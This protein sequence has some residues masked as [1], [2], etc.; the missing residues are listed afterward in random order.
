LVAAQEGSQYLAASGTRRVV[1]DHDE[2]GAAME[3]ATSLCMPLDLEN[4]RLQV[5][6]FD[7]GLKTK[8]KRIRINS[9]QVAYTDYDFGEL[10][11][12]AK[13]RL[14]AGCV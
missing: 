14:G 4:N 9:S 10:H 1:I 13:F 11:S 5:G 6:L 8:S 3:A 2:L 12:W 7:Q